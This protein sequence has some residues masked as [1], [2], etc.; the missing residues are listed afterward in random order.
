MNSFFLLFGSIIFCEL[1][2]IAGGIA[3]A[4]SVKTWYKKLNKP[5]FNPPS[6]VFDPVLN[7]AVR[8]K[9]R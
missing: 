6:V 8:W 5:S 9:N 3:T 4:K 2:G 1:V 7:G